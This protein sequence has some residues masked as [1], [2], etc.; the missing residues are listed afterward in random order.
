MRGPTQ[1]GERSTH[2]KENVAL[3]KQIADVEK[4]HV[5]TIASLTADAEQRAKAAEAET[6]RTRALLEAAEQQ[7][8]ERQTW[9]CGACTFANSHDSASCDM[10]GANK[11]LP[12]S[13]GKRVVGIM[14]HSKRLDTVYDHNLDTIPD[15]EWP[16]RHT[17]PYDSPIS[18]RALP[19]DAVEAGL[20]KYGFTAI[21]SSP[22]RRCLQTAGIVARELGLS[23]IHVDNRLSECRDAAM[24]CFDTANLPR[25]ELTYIEHSEAEELAGCAVHWERDMNVPSDPDDLSARLA[26]VP[27]I[28]GA[29]AGE[30]GNVLLVT[31]GD[32]VN[33]YLPT[34]F[35]DVGKYAADVAGWAV[36]QGPHKG[37]VERD[38]DIL[39]THRIA[40]M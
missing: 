37:K 24:R 33:R 27:S 38:E 28:A 2:R 31:H 13:A 32:L 40:S 22:F 19:R 11:P 3:R 36:V 10:C 23:E 7:L 17:R 29:V 15:A 35:D 18:D 39:A 34:L 8:Q 4:H 25:Q 16:D 21:V 14:R 26:A 6:E 12:E 20:R 9:S 1:N 30:N 5:D